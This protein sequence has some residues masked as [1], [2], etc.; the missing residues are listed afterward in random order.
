ML[1]DIEAMH[2]GQTFQG[3]VRAHRSPAMQVQDLVDME[4]LLRRLRMEASVDMTKRHNPRFTAGLCLRFS[5]VAAQRTL[6]GAEPDTHEAIPELLRGAA[7]GGNREAEAVPLL[8]ESGI[9]ITYAAEDPGKRVAASFVPV[10]LLTDEMLEAVLPE[11]SFGTRRALRWYAAVFDLDV[12]RSPHFNTVV[13]G[14][15]TRGE[16]FTGAVWHLFAQARRTVL[17]LLGTPESSPTYTWHTPDAEG[18]TVWTET[19]RKEGWPGE[20]DPREPAWMACGA[21]V[22]EARVNALLHRLWQAVGGPADLGKLA[23]PWGA[24]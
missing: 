11:Q 1:V 5:A 8:A 14:L 13:L 9:L 10:L 3:W 7:R 21:L 22:T 16:P 24:P 12:R 20:G 19:V 4:S 18:D 2:W 23:G 6:R 17:A 15:N